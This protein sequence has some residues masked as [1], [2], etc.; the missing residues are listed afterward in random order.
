VRRSWAAV[1]A[2]FL[3]VLAGCTTNTGRE[4]TDSPPGGGAFSIVYATSPAGPAAAIPSAVAGGVVTQLSP[5]D[6][7]SVDPGQM[8]VDNEFVVGEL[9]FRTLTG[10]KQNAD[11]VLEVVGDLATDAGSSTDGGRTWRFTLRDGVK[12]EDGRAITSQDIAY[13]IA[14]GFAPELALGRRTLQQWLAGRDNYNAVYKGPYSDGAAPGVQTPDAKTIVFSFDRPRPDLPFVAAQTV[15]APVPADK[16]TKQQ[17][18]GKPVASGPYQVDS[19]T[20]GQKLVLKRNTNWDPATDPIRHQ[21]PD[22]FEFV[23]GVNPAQIS[24][25]LIA[26]RGPDQTA[27]TW[28]SVSPETLPRV[29]DNP[30]VAKRVTQGPTGNVQH[31]Y[32]NTKR[33]T[34]LPVRQALN[35]AIDRDSF[36]KAQGGQAVSAPATTLLSPLTPGHL[37]Y[38]AYNG[39]PAGNPAKAKELLQ[40]KT[41]A[42]TLASANSPVSQRR[43][44]VIKTALERAGFQITMQPVDPQFYYASV[45]KKDNPYDLILAGSSGLWPDGSLA[46]RSQFDG[47]QLRD[48]SEN[49]SQFDAPEIQSRMTALAT[50]PDPTKAIAGWAQLDRDIMAGHAPVVPLTYIRSYTLAGSRVSGLFLSR[51]TN[52]PSLREVHVKPAG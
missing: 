6:F 9:L 8:N 51:V 42:L 33:V 30:E 22:G 37:E 19:Y 39:G 7:Q 52:L 10:T 43:A 11:G 4:N 38:N 27:T 46:L 5:S 2:A 14:R 31:L 47:G 18:G 32:I 23:A 40:G 16:D 13:G 50:E 48:G 28:T 24:E 15:T 25:R 29:V 17:Y 44:L 26:D 36:V 1:A 35:F 12:F 3:A 20:R 45:S 34:E 49:L 21:Y 41:P